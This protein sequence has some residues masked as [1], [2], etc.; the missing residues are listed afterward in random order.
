MSQR[1]TIDK[2]RQIT[3]ILVDKTVDVFKFF[4][5]VFGQASNEQVAQFKKFADLV[6][7][8]MNENISTWWAMMKLLHLII[9]IQL[10]IPSE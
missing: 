1:L 8:C 10:L 7:F 5:A 6:G 9:F 2:T 4:H 3:A